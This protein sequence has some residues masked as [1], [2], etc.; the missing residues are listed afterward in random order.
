MG[1]IPGFALRTRASS[2]RG[3]SRRLDEMHPKSLITTSAIPSRLRYCENGYSCIGG[4]H[5]KKLRKQPDKSLEPKGVL[6][7][8]EPEVIDET[9]EGGCTII[10]PARPPQHTAKLEPPKTKK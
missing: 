9:D 1:I 2:E 6:E 10:V 8:F 4:A 3:S 7:D 5:V